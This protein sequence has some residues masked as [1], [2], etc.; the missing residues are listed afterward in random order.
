[1][2]KESAMRDGFAR[3]TFELPAS[4]WADRVNLV[5]EFNNWD[6]SAMPL[7][8][9]HCDA[10]W[11][12]TIELEVGRRYRFRYLLD[13]KE[14]FNDWEADDHVRNPDRTYDSVLDLTEFVWT[15]SS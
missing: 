5:G 11:Q 9:N 6:T 3:V 4:T 2:R 10:K 8:Y 12:I 15:P 13:G 14:W 7:C 1:M